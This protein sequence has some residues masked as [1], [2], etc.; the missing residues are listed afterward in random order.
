ML[1]VLAP[2]G[3]QQ[4]V[5]ATDR[6]A[7]TTSSGA[8]PTPKFRACSTSLHIPLIQTKR[9]FDELRTVVAVAVFV[10][11]N[12]KLGSPCSCCHDSDDVAGA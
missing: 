5:V 12:D 8:Q 3:D 2:I 10:I 4:T 1:G 9:K 11:E 6:S 7:N